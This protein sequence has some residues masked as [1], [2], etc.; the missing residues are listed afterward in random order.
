MTY[1][2]QI[3]F[4]YLGRLAVIVLSIAAG[5]SSAMAQTASTDNIAPAAG[6]EEVCQRLESAIRAELAAKELPAM[7]LVLVEGDRTVWAQGFGF[8]DA[9]KTKPATAKTVYRVGSVSKLFTDVA[10]MQLAEQGKLS[11]D[12]PVTEYLPE[13]KP[14]NP[15]GDPI[16]L[17]LIMSHRSGLVRESPVGH[18]FDPEEP[19]L[20]ET[21]DSLN[22]TALVYKPGTKTKYSNAG[23]AAVGYVLEQ[24]TGAPFARAMEKALLQPLKMN[25][26]SFDLQPSIRNNLATGW[27]WT[28]DD[29]RFEAPQFA[30]G[31]APAG[32]LYS[33]VL[34]LSKFLIAILNEGDAGRTRILKPETLKMMIHRDPDVS[35]ADQPFGIGFHISD[36]EGQRRVGH[37]GAV[38]GFASQLEA[39]PDRNLGVAAAASLEGGNG[40]VNRLV[41]YAF[42]LLLARQD[43]KPLPDY[44]TT[45]PVPEGRA[46]QAVGS[47]RN[48][49]E[50]LEITEFNGRLYLRQPT[51]RREVRAS[52]AD[53][54]LVVDDVFGYGPKIE[55][56]QSGNITIASKTYQRVHEQ[57]PAEC[58]SKWHGLIGEYG[59]DHN[60]VYILEDRG[61]LVALVEWFFYYPL[62]ELGD[63][64]FAFPSFGMYHDEKLKFTRDENGNATQV[65]AAEMLMKRRS[66]GV[67][68]GETFRI[69]PVKPIDS[70]RAAALAAQPP[71]EQGEYRQAELVELTQFDPTIKLDI[72][73]ATTNNFTGAVFYQQ[74]RAFMQRPAAEAVVA[75]HRKLKEQGLGLLIHDAY[76]PWY[77]TK[78]FWD[79]TPAE[80]KHF[81]A[82]PASGSRHNRGCA[83]DLTLYDLETG[84]P[85]PMVAGY[86]EFSTRS[87]PNYPGGASRQRWY[88]ELLR[89]T[90]ESAGFTIYEFEW[91]HF[92]YKDWRK[93]R[94]GN[95]TFEDIR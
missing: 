12:A 64:E 55:F 1:R 2:R 18:Y 63:D 36:F 59:W 3:A 86:D 40:V 19:T 67:K 82:N 41:E 6:Y 13:L 16:T 54:S 93:Y 52:D 45:G 34:D 58:P 77:V 20:A 88:R 80:M 22:R 72:R 48:G 90:M 8:A 24:M 76:R 94:I 74:P 62:E 10:V 89:R 23:I 85:I 49:D 5:L 69:T 50:T 71:Q 11:L 66:I 39:L 17:R 4:L 75:A 28:Y 79:A 26:S 21:V 68:D 47:Y 73:Y 42:R 92:D 31:T 37:A 32:N 57:A 27:M 56:D 91:W 61:K 60:T 9:K 81:V 30:L 38:Y 29:R 7:S 35:A 51:L 78:M 84:E 46:K 14:R 33:N 87:Y 43:Q 44:A 25:D 65:V 83:V 15:F 95:V 53:G 70:L